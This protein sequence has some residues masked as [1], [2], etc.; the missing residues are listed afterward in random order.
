MS[1]RNR[2]ALLLVGSLL[3]VGAALLFLF[4]LKGGEESPVAGTPAAGGFVAPAPS[5]SPVEPD[6]KAAPERLVFSGRDPFNPAEGGGSIEP[7][8]NVSPGAPVPGVSP[9]AT[10]PAAPTGGS[11]ASIGG[12]TVVLIDIFTSGGDEQA[13]VEVDGTVF[14]VSEGESFDGGRFELVTID[15]TCADFLYGDQSFTLCE[16]ANK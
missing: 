3:V 14:T 16:T 11:S 7:L 12:S 2:R 5:P 6:K 13:Q 8:V 9:A 4:V 15:G 1:S 10:P